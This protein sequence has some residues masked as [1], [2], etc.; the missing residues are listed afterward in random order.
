MTRNNQY[1]VFVIVRYYKQK[2]AYALPTWPQRGLQSFC[3]STIRFL[4]VCQSLLSTDTSTRFMRKFIAIRRERVGIRHLPQR[5]I[6][7]WVATNQRVVMRP[8]LPSL[9]TTMQKN[10]MI[11]TSWSS[12][13]WKHLLLKLLSW[14]TNNQSALSEVTICLDQTFS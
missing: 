11:K 1:I 13:W 9:D 8:F 7:L 4:N 6:I 10:R 14:Q 3:E 5:S 12:R 2:R